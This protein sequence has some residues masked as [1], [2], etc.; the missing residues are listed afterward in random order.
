MEIDLDLS[1]ETEK[2]L[3]DRAERSGQT[4][5]EVVLGILQAHVNELARTESMLDGRYDDLKSGRVKSIPGDDV[6]AYFQEKSGAMR[7]L[8]PAA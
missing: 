8:K 7:R 5:Q 6:V 3:N 4:V 2:K 1:P